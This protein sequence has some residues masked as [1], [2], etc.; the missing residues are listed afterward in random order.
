MIA[1][2]ALVGLAGCAAGW[3]QRAMDTAEAQR[4]IDMHDA[5]QPPQAVAASKPA[6]RDDA[7]TC[8]GANGCLDPGAVCVLDSATATAGHCRRPM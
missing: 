6:P 3:E 5:R 1:V 8:F 4:R 2:L 7:P